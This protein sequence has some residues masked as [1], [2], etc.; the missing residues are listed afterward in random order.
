MLSRAVSTVCRAVPAR[1]PFVFQS[2]VARWFRST[3]WMCS[4]DSPRVLGTRYVDVRSDTVTKPTAQMSLAMMDAQVG[5][6]V[7]GEGNSSART[8]V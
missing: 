3:A 6:D 7:F 5:D 2:S 4:D 1:K 8:R